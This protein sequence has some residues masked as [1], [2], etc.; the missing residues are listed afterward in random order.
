MFKISNYIDKIS[1]GY[2]HSLLFKPKW[3]LTK[4]WAE[5]V[6][7]IIIPVSVDVIP[8]SKFLQMTEKCAQV[9]GLILQ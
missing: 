6:I 4:N 5:S 7:G 2:L 3:E 9:S 1:C 8:S